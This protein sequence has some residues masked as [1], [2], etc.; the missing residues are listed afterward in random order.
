MN[1]IAGATVVDNGASANDATSDG[2]ST[3][4]GGVG[5]TA[6]SG[7]TTGSSSKV[8]QSG[9]RTGGGAGGTGGNSSTRSRNAAG[10]SLAGSSSGAASSAAAMAQNQANAQNQSSSS[11]GGSSSMMQSLQSG[12]PNPF[13]AFNFG[14]QNQQS[15]QT[16]QQSVA[17]KRGEKNWANPQ[18][19]T[20]N[21]PIER[22]IR[23]V[24][25]A[26]HLTLMPEGRGKQ[27]MRII[28]L[29]GSTV[30]S[31]DNLVG[32]VWDR[33]DS[34]GMAGRGMYW[35]PTLTM[36]VEPGGERR[37][38][39]LHALLADSGFDVRGQQRSRAIAGPRRLRAAR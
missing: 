16:D 4:T 35:R 6:E 18:A 38:A 10:G 12:M 3:R 13:Q 25:D 19:S 28:P 22:P 26:D 31:V 37:Y 1:G 32:A 29:Q 11:M 17:K 33:I 20:A 5:G 7:P 24:C 14:Q 15:S 2:A 34:W 27:G 30:A 8:A 23:I 36:E 39:E 21:I 9:A